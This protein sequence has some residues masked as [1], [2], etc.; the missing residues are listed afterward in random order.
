MLILDLE[1]A[2]PVTLA[3]ADLQI[4]SDAPLPS[5]LAA[6]GVI[7]IRFGV[8]S[9]GRGFTQARRLRTVYHFKGPI[10]AVGHV[11]A[12]QIDYLRRC[13]FSHARIDEAQL[14]HWQQ[15][16]QAIRHHFQHMPD[17]PRTPRSPRMA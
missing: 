13:G 12:D 4:D 16:H 3:T 17:S 11:I 14:V 5:S 8:F 6:P 9:D 10:I 15:A 1:T 7:A 2:T